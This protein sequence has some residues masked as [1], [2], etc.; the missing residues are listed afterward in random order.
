VVVI[1]HDRVFRDSE[2]RATGIFPDITPRLQDSIKRLVS[3]VAYLKMERSEAKKTTNRLLYLNPTPL[4]EAKNRLNIQE[5][6]V[7]NTSWKELFEQ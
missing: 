5:T 1:A 7:S 4:I 6:F 2:G 3:V